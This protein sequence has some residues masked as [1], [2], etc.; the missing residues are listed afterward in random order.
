M[1]N[2][3]STQILNI[4]ETHISRNEELA[5]IISHYKH[6]YN[7][8]I[9]NAPDTDTYSGIIVC[10]RKTERLISS[11]ILEEG[12]LMLVKIQN[13]ASNVIKNIFSIYCKSSNA[14]QQKSLISKMQDK[15]RL[16]KIENLVIL[17]DFNFVS[18]VLDRNSQT[19][20][21]IDLET[22]KKYGTLLKVN[23]HCKIV[24]GLQI[25]IEDYILIILKAIRK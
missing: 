15:I 25:Q 21:R 24:S 20:N 17:G 4:Q 18:S 3:N 9:T 10:I 1:E 14:E 19:L 23:F 6:L 22:K 8:E 2:V 16:E 5:E 7:F 13:E 12:R 11:E